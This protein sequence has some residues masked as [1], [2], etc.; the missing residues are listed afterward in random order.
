MIRCSSRRGFAT[1]SAI[2]ILMLLGTVMLLM[3][4][5]LR[6]QA[7]R[8][9]RDD[10]EAQLRQLL[11]VGSL[12]AGDLPKVWGA[13]GAQAQTLTVSLPPEL[14]SRDAAVRINVPRSEDPGAATVEINARLDGKTAVELLRFSRGDAGWSLISVDLQ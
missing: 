14:I 7:K 11:H 1:A 12:I 13:G 6:E 8:T 2:M 9:L 10:Q 3:M 5:H 4:T